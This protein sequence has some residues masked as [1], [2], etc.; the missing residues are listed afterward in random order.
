M[1]RPWQIWVIAGICLA[2]GVAAMSWTSLTVLRLDQ[3]ETEAR[4]NARL[5][6]NVRLALWRMDAAMAEIIGVENARSHS[7]Y[8]SFYQTERAYTKLYAE[9]QK[10]EV[11][12]PSP[13]LVGEEKYIRLHFQISP[14]GKVTSPQVPS[15]NMRDIA[16]V[17]YVSHEKIVESEKV[18]RQFR[19]L[20]PAS[21]LVGTALQTPTNEFIYNISQGQQELQQI[22]NDSP[23]LW[24]E[25]R[26]NL[27]LQKRSKSAYA[28]F[29]KPGV[30]DVLVEQSVIETGIMKPVWIGDELVYAR[31][32]SQGG[33]VTIQGIW[34]DWPDIRKWLLDEIKDLF[35]EAQLE[36]VKETNPS[37]PLRMLASVPVRLAPG[38]PAVGIGPGDSPIRLTLFMACAGLVVAMVAVITLLFGVVALSERRAAFVSAVTHELRTP[39]TTFRMYSEMLAEGMVKDESKRKQYL[40]TLCVEADR[41]SHLVENVLSYAR[42]ERGRSGGQIEDVH[43]SEIVERIEERLAARAEQNGMRVEVDVSAKMPKV[44]TDS[45]A[46]EQILFNLVDN[47]CKYAAEAEDK[48]IHVETGSNGF[49]GILRVH[50]HGPGIERS[51]AARLFQPFTKSATEAAHT[52]AGVGLGLALSRRLARQLGGDLKLENGGQP[53]ASFA[54]TL[55]LSTS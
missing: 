4:A 1:S 34:I 24:Q 28:G 25:Q 52:A 46:V 29:R 23:V 2:I 26:N 43:L 47:A 30:E 17:K 51:D 54:L 38:Q 19:S 6:E 11:L 48:T 50:D 10:G 36:P 20:V 40:N 39:L 35:S 33:K 16:E 9:I 37:S 14:E 3:A 44:R 12:V 53:G 45:S 27:E 18:L 5:E 31:E 8:N 15:G 7:A 42:L 32:V 49:A 21:A 55:P 13:L 22:A 41:L